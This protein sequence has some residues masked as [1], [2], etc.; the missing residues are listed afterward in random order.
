MCTN[1]REITVLSLLD[2]KYNQG[3]LVR[4]PKIKYEVAE[5]DNIE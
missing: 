1:K 5:K 2:C 4:G 3:T